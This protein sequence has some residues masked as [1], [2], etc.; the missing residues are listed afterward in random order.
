MWL[1]YV[2]ILLRLVDF[3]I[4]V[5]SENIILLAG[6]AMVWFSFLV[7]LRSVA[8]GYVKENKTVIYGT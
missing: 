4:L 7:V 6:E 2:Y 8:L 3:K 5:F 1:C